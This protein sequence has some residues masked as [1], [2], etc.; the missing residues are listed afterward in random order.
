MGQ[1][2]NNG[3]L[4]GEHRLIAAGSGGQGILTLGKLL[5]MAAMEEG[6]SVTFMPSY[7]TEVRGGTANCQVVLSNGPIYSPVVEEADSLIILNQLS[8]ERFGPRLREGGWLIINSSGVDVAAPEG[9]PGDTTVPVPAAERAAEMG[10]VRVGNVIMLGA[11]VEV[12][13][14]VRP[15]SCRKALREVFTGPKAGVLDLNLEAFDAG[16]ALAVK[17]TSQR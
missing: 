9:A 15:A 17:T 12:S 5:C 6:R 3:S 16:S 4:D 10:D 2:E 14:L 7:G 1:G 13:G 11:F 8:Q